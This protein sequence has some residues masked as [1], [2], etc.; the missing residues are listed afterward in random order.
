MA[1]KAKPTQDF[2]ALREIRD[3]IVI[4]KDGSYRGVL[5]GSSINFAL[6]STDEREA[7]IMQYQNFLNSLDFSIQIHLQS[8]KLD[9]QP[10]L[11]SLEAVTKEHVNELIKIQSREYMNFIKTFTEATNVMTK[12]FF[13]VVPYQPS[14]IQ[15]TDTIMSKLPFLSKSKQQTTK[16]ATKEDFQNNKVQLEQRLGVVA[17]GLGRVGVKTARLNTEELIELYFKIFN[18]GERGVP[19]VKT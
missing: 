3:G 6:K 19:T 4:L 11:A 17:G 12:T 13:I 7:V 5:I 9:I 8:K 10:Y 2:V 15:T 1:I 14:V 16:I 18:P